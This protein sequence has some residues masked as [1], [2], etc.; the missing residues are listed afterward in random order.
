M[1]FHYYSDRSLKAS[2]R[3]PN[4]KVPVEKVVSVAGSYGLT[5]LSPMLDALM[6]Q[7][8]AESNVGKAVRY[9]LFSLSDNL[10]RQLSL[11]N[12]C[13]DTAS[14]E[15]L[16]NWF[17]SAKQLNKDPSILRTIA[18][19]VLSKANDEERIE[20]FRRRLPIEFVTDGDALEI[21]RLILSE[22]EGSQYER[23]ELAL[24]LYAFEPTDQYLRQVL[25]LSNN[26]E[27]T[28]G[29]V[30]SFVPKSQMQMVVETLQ[31]AID[32][33]RENGPN[34]L[35]LR[36]NS[37]RLLLD[38]APGVGCQFI[39]DNLDSLMLEGMQVAIWMLEAI[40][41]E[42]VVTWLRGRDLLGNEEIDLVKANVK[43]PGIDTVGFVLEQA[44]LAHQPWWGER[45][46]PDEYFDFFEGFCKTSTG[47][48]EL[49]GVESKPI[50]REFED[51]G[52]QLTIKWKDNTTTI[53]EVVGEGEH[54]DGSA[55]GILQQELEKRGIQERFHALP[56]WD[57]S[58]ISIF[59]KPQDL[60]DLVEAFAL[61]DNFGIDNGYYYRERFLAR[62]ELLLDQTLK[63]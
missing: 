19:A 5:E 54:I 42:D 10:Q 20:F 40:S 43:M 63:D 4:W 27:E 24:K 18:D 23:R 6:D 7:H 35:V 55:H 12:E 48:L 45:D 22:E 31:S 2:I 39:K 29:D 16:Q 62:L 61:S 36:G 57:H 17:H 28:L 3:F 25:K 59:M 33:K 34:P 41:A 47:Y 8:S 14:T 30:F 60:K 26:I 50:K 38:R 11:F 37:V 44:R 9:K 21:Q 1:H 49:A 53:L 15:S 56:N 52:Y 46:L 58:G 51:D 13:V 32:Q